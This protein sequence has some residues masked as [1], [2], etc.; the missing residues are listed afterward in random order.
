MWCFEN[1]RECYLDAVLDIVH[2]GKHHDRDVAIH[3]P[4]QSDRVGKLLQNRL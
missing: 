1:M 4:R 2:G 3:L